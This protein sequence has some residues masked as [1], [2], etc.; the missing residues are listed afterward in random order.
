MRSPLKDIRNYCIQCG[1]SHKGARLCETTG[2]Y[3]W[4]YRMGKNPFRKQK[5]QAQL[6]AS[7]RNLNGTS[8]K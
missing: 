1:G 3:L 2:C 8:N 6:E 4:P 7:R 5:T